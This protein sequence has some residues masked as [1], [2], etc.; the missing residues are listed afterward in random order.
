LIDLL[1]LLRIIVFYFRRIAS[2]FASSP[3]SLSPKNLEE[4]AMIQRSSCPQADDARKTWFVV[5][6]D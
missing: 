2:F 3:P 6:D 4:E 5:S 1:L